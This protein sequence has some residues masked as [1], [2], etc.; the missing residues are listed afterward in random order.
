[1][2]KRIWL[3]PP[4]AFARVGSSKHPCDNFCW[5]PDDLAPEGTARTRIVPMES[6]KVAED[7]AVTAYPPNDPFVFKD[8]DAFRPVC[9]FFELH[10]EWRIG[11]E[12]GTGRLTKAILD[13]L[14]IPLEALTWRVNVYNLK[15]FH[16]TKSRGDQVKA[17]V[18][19]RGDSHGRQELEGKSPTE[20]GA[21]LVPD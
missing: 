18:E 13:Q 9:P 17:S 5:G 15:A 10:A 2:I 1:M 4:L 21:A 19:I 7:G 16:L 12:A 11:G 3:H 14:K 20:G 6:L 8:G